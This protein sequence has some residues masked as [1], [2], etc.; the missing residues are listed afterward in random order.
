MNEN[1][2]QKLKQKLQYVKED[3]KA[4]QSVFLLEVCVIDVIAYFVISAFHIGGLFGFL[5]RLICL[6]I[7]VGVLL[8]VIK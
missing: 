7:L 2:I 6:V 3:P 5:L 4:S 1:W 8:K